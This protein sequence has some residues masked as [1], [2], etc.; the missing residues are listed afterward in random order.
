MDKKIIKNIF[1]AWQEVQEKKLS[2]KQK[3]HMDADKDG[4]IDADDLGNLRKEEIEHNNCGTP[5][6]CGQCNGE[7][8]LQKEEVEEFD[9][10][11]IKGTPVVS[12]SDFGDKDYTKDKYGRTVP[13]KLKKDDPRV[14]FRKEEVEQMGEL[15]LVKFKTFVSET[16]KQTKNATPPETM[17]DKFKGAN[18]KKMATDNNVGNPKH[19]DITTYDQAVKDV[20][21]ASKAKAQSKGRNG[22]NLNNGDSKQPKG[23]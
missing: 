11:A 4:D 19:A 2:A 12:L 23:V 22:D 18:S 20:F 13:K 14:K 3:K 17:L 8:M 10:A 5:D 9:E 21:I 16:N 6:C 15:K 7:G 1:A